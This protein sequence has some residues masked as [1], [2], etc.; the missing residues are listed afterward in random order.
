MAITDADQLAEII[1]RLVEDGALT[2][3]LWTLSEIAG[4]F[5]QRQNR[6]NR[7]T[8]LM[9]AE[10]P[11]IAATAGT[12][13]YDLPDDWIATQRVTWKSVAGVISPLDR[14]DRW[15]AAAL[16]DQTNPPTKP[17]MY[18]DHAGGSRRIEIFP[19]PATDGTIGLL[20]ASVLE[21]LNFNPAAPDI[22]DIPDDFVPYV[23]YGVLEDL[24]SKD[25]GTGRGRDLGRAAYCRAR[26]EEG[27]AVAALF[28]GGF[29]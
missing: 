7:D 13:A 27:V 10:M 18:D 29:V 9:L 28:L 21:L 19:T 4:L 23:L 12:A 22:F 17:I 16:I 25:A 14:G 5:N 15:A 6:F 2:S 8:F 24:L 26:Y 20:Y 1:W 3:G 11:G